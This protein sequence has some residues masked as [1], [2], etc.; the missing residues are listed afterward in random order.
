[1]CVYVCVEAKRTSVVAEF[2]G[3]TGRIHRI[4]VIRRGGGAHAEDYPHGTVLGQGLQLGY[5]CVQTA[6]NQNKPS[7]RHNSII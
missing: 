6:S 1:M 5:F 4:R 2:F 7:D 3:A